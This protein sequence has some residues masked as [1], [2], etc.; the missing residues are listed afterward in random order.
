MKLGPYT[1]SS[2]SKDFEDLE[3]LRKGLARPLRYGRIVAGQRYRAIRPAH[4]HRR[5]WRRCRGR[6]NNYRL[7]RHR[8][9]PRFIPQTDIEAVTSRRG[10]IKRWARVI[11]SRK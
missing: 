7:C 5:P 8:S 11:T 9:L 6:G 1:G 2:W 10:A 4:D 3:F